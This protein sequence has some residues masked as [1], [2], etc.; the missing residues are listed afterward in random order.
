MTTFTFS[1]EKE[2]FDEAIGVDDEKMKKIFRKV[3]AL[4]M[5]FDRGSEV[6]EQII[7]LYQDPGD[8]ALAMFF[9]GQ[10]GGFEREFANTMQQ[11]RKG[12]GGGMSIRS[13]DDFDRA[14]EEFFTGG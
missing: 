5:E 9:Y 4:R 12:R 8:L 2:S 11:H 7:N 6:F 14:F 3:L 13:A 1:H 10:V